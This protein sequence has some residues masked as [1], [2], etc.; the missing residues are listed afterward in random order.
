MQNRRVYLI[1]L[2][3]TGTTRG[4]T[5]RVPGFDQYYVAGWVFELVLHQAKQ[6]FQSKP[7]LLAGYLDPFLTLAARISL[8]CGISSSKLT[9]DISSFHRMKLPVESIF[10]W[11]QHM[12]TQCLR[13]P[14][15]LYISKK[16]FRPGGMAPSEWTRSVRAVRDTPVAGYSA[17]GV[18][19]TCRV[20]SRPPIAVSSRSVGLLF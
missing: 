1:G 9:I 12:R 2:A 6:C 20:A 15:P 7:G 8:N 3:K 11:F 13:L 16:H 19:T 5:G 10:N 17:P 4:M 18:N 14:K